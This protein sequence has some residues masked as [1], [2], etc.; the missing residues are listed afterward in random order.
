MYGE[1]AE[2]TK[3]AANNRHYPDH[4]YMHAHFRNPKDS[5]ICNELYLA[6][7]ML[8]YVNSP[9][10]IHV[11]CDMHVIY[12]YGPYIRSELCVYVCIYIC[13]LLVWHTC[14]SS[15]LAC[16][17]SCQCYCFCVTLSS[18]SCIISTRVIIYLRMP[19]SPCLL[20]ACFRSWID[21]WRKDVPIDTISFAVHKAR[22]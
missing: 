19:C 9:P 3:E 1:K 12:R 15:A 7:I 21:W 13:L 8:L 11:W 18:M 14:A 4:T 2:R 17:R 16:S 6:T 10:C 5:W 22:G 20:D